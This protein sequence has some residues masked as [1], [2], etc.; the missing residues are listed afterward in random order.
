LP[1]TVNRSRVSDRCEARSAVESRLGHRRN[2][3]LGV[4]QR[5]ERDN[6]QDAISRLQ[7]LKAVHQH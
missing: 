5:R 2:R 7:L 1:V 3:Y 4:V 6:Y